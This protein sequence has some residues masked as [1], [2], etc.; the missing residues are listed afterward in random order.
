MLL[1]AGDGRQR[2]YNALSGDISPKRDIAIEYYRSDGAGADTPTHQIWLVSTLDPSKRRLLFTHWRDASLLFSDDEK[3]LVINDRQA[4]NESHLQLFYRKSELE[5]EKVTDLSEAAWHF[6]DEKQRHNW[7]DGF[8]H[9]YVEALRWSDSTPPTLLLM[10]RG[11]VDSRNHT[12]DWY[13]LYDVEAKS[14]ST[15]F[16]AHN[17]K[18]TKVETE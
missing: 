3:W 13:C 10:L 7:K 15:D 2:Y 14:F 8:D 17:R 9:H 16:E 5:Y 18:S 4:S 12:S 1:Q 11:H 6:F